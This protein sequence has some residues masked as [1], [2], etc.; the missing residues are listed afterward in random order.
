MAR[1]VKVKPG[2]KRTHPNADPKPPREAARLLALRLLARGMN[3]VDAERE[4][5]LG[6]GWASRVLRGVVRSPPLQVMQV[7]QDA[8]GVPI[9][10]WLHDARGPVPDVPRVSRQV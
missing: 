8:F 4:M 6:N 1:K 5:G 2:S 10:A 9:S 7:V 3:R